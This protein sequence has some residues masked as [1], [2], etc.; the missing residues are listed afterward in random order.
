MYCH[1]ISDP[2][3]RI[4]SDF[5]RLRFSLFF[6]SNSQDIFLLNHEENLPLKQDFEAVAMIAFIILFPSGFGI[7]GG[8]KELMEL[9]EKEK[10]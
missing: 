7:V 3:A 9:T 2:S 10:G 5:G 4:K 1:Y 8:V 6:Y